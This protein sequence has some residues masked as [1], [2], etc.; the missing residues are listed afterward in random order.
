MSRFRNLLRRKRAYSKSIGVESKQGESALF[1]AHRGL[2]LVLFSATIFSQM[3]SKAIRSRTA[4][5]FARIDRQMLVD[6]FEQWKN[7]LCSPENEHVQQSH[8]TT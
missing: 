5:E 2:A 4:T 8:P 6:G 3:N 7:Y 1:L